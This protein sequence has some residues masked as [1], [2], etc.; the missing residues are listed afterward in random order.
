MNGYTR[1]IPMTTKARNRLDAV[2]AS[3]SEDDPQQFQYLLRQ[4]TSFMETWS[5]KEQCPT[6]TMKIAQAVI[7]YQQV[8]KSH[9][10]L[11]SEIARLRMSGLTIQQQ[12]ADNLAY[13]AEE[14]QLAE[15]HM[16]NLI[17]GNIEEVERLERERG[18]DAEY[19]DD[20]ETK[21]GLRADMYSC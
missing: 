14:K 15:Y 2:I 21:A 17:N 20:D 1:P 3:A 7:D 16:L 18:L 11:Y 5:A 12:H 8:S 9:A 10:M 13:L 19:Q 6:E 4:M